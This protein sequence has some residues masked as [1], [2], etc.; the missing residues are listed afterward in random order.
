MKK[1][2][3]RKKITELEFRI[4][5]KVKEL[6]TKHNLSKMEL[7]EAIGLANSF[8]GKVESYSHPD[9]YNFNHLNRIA[10]VLKL[11]SIRELL[12]SEIPKYEDIEVIYEMIPKINKDGSESK[13]LE[14][15]I[16]EIRPIE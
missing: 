13:Q 6:R 4:I 16:L 12:P 2:T 10:I 3:S 8:V 11:K 7:S 1:F 9:K 5:E 14:V 15:N